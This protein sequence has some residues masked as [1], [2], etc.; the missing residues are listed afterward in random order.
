[1]DKTNKPKMS[2]FKKAYLKAL[3]EFQDNN[4]QIV[5]QHGDKTNGDTD[6][7]HTP[8]KGVND[9]LTQESLKS[10]VEDVK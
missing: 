1:M 6:I 4:G 8:Y 2:Q 5:G 3:K 10:H 7:P 9:V